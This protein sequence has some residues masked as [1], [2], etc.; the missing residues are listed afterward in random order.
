[1]SMIKSGNTKPEMIVRRFLHGKGLRY[2]LHNRN[3]PGKP[4]L[5]LAKY[6]TVIFVNGCFW[7]GHANCRYFV[8]PKT[9]KEWWADK[10]NGNIKNDLKNYSL[11]RKDKWQVI[12][13][14]ECD[15]KKEKIDKRLS[16]LL[17]QILKK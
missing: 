16:N 4:D 8:L 15:L 11:L 6:Q 1:M 2:R 12:N 7:H 14:W 17:K 5:V 10:L 3:L 13:I 9:R